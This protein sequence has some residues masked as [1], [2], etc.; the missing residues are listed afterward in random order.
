MHQERSMRILIVG[1]GALGGYFGGCLVHAG[2]DVTFMARPHRTAQL[3]RDGLR[4]IS[5]H[6]DFA[7]PAVAVL[8][9][10]IRDPFDLVLVAVKS[11]SLDE[12]MEQFAPAVGPDT[13]ILPLL[14]GMGHLDRLG[15]RFS[16]ARVLGGMAN[17]SVGVD[18]EGCI[19]QFIPNHDLVFGEMQGGFSART[20]AVDACF[21]DARFNGRASDVVMQDM[22]EKF[23]QLG[24]GAGITCLMRASIGDI[25]AA[26]GGREAMFELFAECC[27]I[28]TAS[29]F[30]P[31]PA[32]IEF[33]RALITTV[34]S[35]LKWS[36]LRDIERGSVTEGEHILGDMVA[37]ARALG[38]ATPILNLART[39]VAAYEISRLRSGAAS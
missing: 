26:P 28:A 18:A 9:G 37:R 24:L 11:Y 33:D 38:I 20:R 36:M 6:G 1:A 30:P 16:A 32:F 39:H 23:V 31:R 21:N 19:V 13:A 22:W 25:L 4:I 27:A 5:P 2:R 29:G 7:V 8:A 14:N 10:D 15:A 35:P 34:A 3:A 17:I 12:A